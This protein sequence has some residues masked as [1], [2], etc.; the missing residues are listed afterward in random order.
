[1]IVN[2]IVCYYQFVCM[3]TDI[4]YNTFEVLYLWTICGRGSSNLNIFL[5]NWDW[6]QIM[7]NNVL[8]TNWYWSQIIISNDSRELVWTV[9]SSNLINHNLPHTL[10]GSELNKN[11]L[12]LFV[13]FWMHSFVRSS[14]GT[15]F[16]FSFDR[17]DGRESR[18]RKD[19]RSSVTDSY[20]RL[21]L[22]L[23]KV[24]TRRA[25]IMIC[26]AVM[27]YDATNQRIN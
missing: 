16:D 9:A 23:K 7:I 11:F 4:I 8:L 19:W 25:F 2:D 6:S 1:M 26:W 10:I 24:D 17:R 5:A 12:I 14:S 21:H 15:I 20:Y 22:Y 27:L 13:T 3:Y 18:N